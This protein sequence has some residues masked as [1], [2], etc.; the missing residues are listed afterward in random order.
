MAEGRQRSHEKAMDKLMDAKKNQTKLELQPLQLA[1]AL[2]MDAQIAQLQVGANQLG[3]FL[4]LERE[5]NILLEA[6]Q[7]IGKKRQELMDE[8]SRR[9]HL[10]PA[11]ALVGVNGEALAAK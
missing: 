3:G 2:V 4:K 9:V 5:A 7:L 11:N 8:W 1:A 6:A 10:A